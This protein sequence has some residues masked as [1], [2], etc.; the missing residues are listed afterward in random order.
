MKGSA[1]KIDATAAVLWRP[2]FVQLIA[3]YWL[4]FWFIVSM[5]VHKSVDR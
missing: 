3:R 4:F 2:I 5:I 1:S